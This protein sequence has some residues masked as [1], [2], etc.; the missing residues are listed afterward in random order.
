MLRSSAGGHFVSLDRCAPIKSAHVGTHV[1]CLLRDGR[2]A[3]LFLWYGETETTLA[4]LWKTQVFHLRYAF[5]VLQIRSQCLNPGNYRA[6]NLIQDS[7]IITT[8]PR[9]DFSM[10][11]PFSGVT[12]SACRSCLSTEVLVWYLP[13]YTKSYTRYTKKYLYVSTR[14]YSTAVLISIIRTYNKI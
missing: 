6:F 11:F 9:S 13:Y 2:R 14:I 5:Q 4:P 10:H 8:T 3:A 7:S 12:L 1:Y